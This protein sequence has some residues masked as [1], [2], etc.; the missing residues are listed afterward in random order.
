MYRMLALAH[1]NT[2]VVGMLSG[3]MATIDIATS[4]VT[5]EVCSTTFH[6]E[7]VVHIPH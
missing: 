3:K 6:T 7:D 4:N 5:K 2:V 1:A